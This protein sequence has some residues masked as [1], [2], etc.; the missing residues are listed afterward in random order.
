MK[1]RKYLLPDG[2]CPFDIWMNEV[3]DLRAKAKI[4]IR[5]KRFELGN[6]GDIKPISNGVHELRIHEGQGY[7][8]YFGRLGQEVVLLLCGGIK[9]TQQRDIKQALQYWSQNHAK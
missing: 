3:S 8:V 4:Q 1:I 5:L 6:L 2:R 7:R 9:S